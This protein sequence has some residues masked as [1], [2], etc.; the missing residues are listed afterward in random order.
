MNE[1]ERAAA[2][3]RVLDAHQPDWFFGV[4]PLT[5]DI[6]STTQCAVGQLYGT[7]AQGWKLIWETAEQPVSAFGCGFLGGSPE[8]NEAWRHEIVARRLAIYE[9]EA[10]PAT[11]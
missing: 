6:G 9:P 10:E 7:F 5:I 11:V 8:L 1:A 4:D 2:G 3:A